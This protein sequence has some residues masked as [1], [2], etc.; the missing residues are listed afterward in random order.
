MAARSI[1]WDAKFE[2]GIA[3]VDFEHKELVHLLNLALER[4]ATDDTQEF[5]VDVLAEIDAK[6]SA[7]FALEE[8]VMRTAKYP[9]FATHKADHERLL[10]EIQVIQDS[11]HPGSN[12]GIVDEVSMRLI[13]W[14]G[15]HFRSE[16]AKFHAFMKGR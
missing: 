14:F 5:A 10:D 8:K 1:P 15:D 4:L 7:H 12:T 9:G 3:E 13:A 11:C 2:T 6:I 16:D